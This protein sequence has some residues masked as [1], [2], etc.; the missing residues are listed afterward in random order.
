MTDEELV[1]QLQTANRP[2]AVEELTRR[3]W[4]AIVR[5]CGAYLGDDA[6]GEDVAQ[7]TF[8]KLLENDE[9]PTG[10]IKP[11][12]YRVARNHCLDIHRRHQ[13]SPTFNRP[14][15]TG[16]D[17]GGGSSGP[18]TKAARNERQELIRQ[19]IEQMPD[20]YRAVMI[21][22]YYENLSREEMAAALGVSEQAVKGR[23][24][25]ASEYL[26][27]QLQKLTGTR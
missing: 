6:L 14:I 8:A 4:S 15:R 21:L 24:V 20:D 5:F 16:V 10:A 2:A 1:A 22:K 23:L 7:E 13:R 18:G 3:Y 27:E 12:L 9:P 19:I 26:H 25:R 17:A 11:W